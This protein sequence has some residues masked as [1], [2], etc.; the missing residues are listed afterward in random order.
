MLP[1]LVATAAPLINCIQQLPQLYKT[2]TTK[3]ATDLSLQ[4]LLLI[5]LTNLLWFLHG[6][7]IRDLALIL[8]GS[9]S[10]IING[11]LLILYLLYTATADTIV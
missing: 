2:Y 1:Q 6:V 7:F 9:I 11:T 5:L 3:E 4:S 10:L 8:S